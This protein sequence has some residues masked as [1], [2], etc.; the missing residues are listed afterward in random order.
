MGMRQRAT[1]QTSPALS[2]GVYAAVRG[3]AANRTS[4]TPRLPAGRATP[5]PTRR[6]RPRPRPGP[7][8]RSPRPPGAGR[9][10]EG[11]GAVLGAAGNTRA[12]GARLVGR[13]G[14]FECRKAGGG[15]GGS[16]SG[17]PPRAATWRR[18]VG[19]P[20]K[21]LGAVRRRAA[22]LRAGGRRR[23]REEVRGCRRGRRRPSAAAR[24]LRGRGTGEKAGNSC[25]VAS[26]GAGGWWPSRESAG[27]G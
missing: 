17:W 26:P 12:P 27:A 5:P 2:S 6:P 13:G 15:R 9:G 20:G 10:R 16:Q 11:P 1:D 23:A 21:R 25:A 24:G 3:R 7:A 14:H 22:A 18:A 4:P 8:P 19:V